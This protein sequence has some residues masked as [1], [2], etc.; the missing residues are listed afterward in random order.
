MVRRS[1][2]GI[3]GLV[4]AGGLLVGCGSETRIDA[5]NA[6]RSSHPAPPLV[7]GV[8]A[9]HEGAGHSMSSPSMQRLHAAHSADFERGF[10]TA[11]IEHHQGAVDMSRMALD[12]MQ[13]PEVRAAAEK[14]IAD[15][16]EEI[17]Q[18]RLWLTRW[19]G[20]GPEPEMAQLARAEMDPMLAAFKEDCKTDCDR[21]FL[22]HMIPH[23]Q[24]A[25]DMAKMAQQKAT[26][27]ELKKLA[28]RM[29]EMQR[30]EI[31][32]FQRWLTPP[33]R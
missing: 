17:A 1:G 21:A 16:R 6:P 7:P 2:L 18:M 25:V 12:R 19:Y 33:N 20:G 13:R 10:L 22:T 4:L 3:A 23:H 32:Q 31:D 24:G 5:A 30:R 29:L 9:E 27:P 28:G 15:Q 14:I 11:M 26:R 8:S